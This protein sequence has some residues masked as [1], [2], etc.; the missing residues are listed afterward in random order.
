MWVT[1]TQKFSSVY[2]FVIFFFL[3]LDTGYKLVFVVYNDSKADLVENEVFPV[4][5]RL[6][7]DVEI[8]LLHRDMFPGYDKFKFMDK[9]A[10]L[11]SAFVVL[12]SQ[13]F[14]SCE[15]CNYL[16][17]TFFPQKGCQENKVV[18]LVIAQS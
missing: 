12:L 15:C 16:L 9:H 14:D 6:S 13:D 2:E 3:S 18:I 8:V 1:V 4:L 10:E 17:T 11:A 5:K 7:D